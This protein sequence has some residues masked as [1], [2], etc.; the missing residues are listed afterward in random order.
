M[1]VVLVVRVVVRPLHG[2]KV[3]DVGLIREDHRHRIFGVR[4]AEDCSNIVFT[5]FAEAKLLRHG[6]GVLRGPYDK[7]M[8]GQ[9]PPDGTITEVGV[10][11]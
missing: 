10:L 8:A 9:E 6:E 5:Q 2:M 4:I 3:M 7:P 1:F 11:R